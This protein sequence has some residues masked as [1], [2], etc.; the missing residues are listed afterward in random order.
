MYGKCCKMAMKGILFAWIYV[1]IALVLL[2]GGSFAK[3]FNRPKGGR[4]KNISC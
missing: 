1:W 4:G 3:R 2:T